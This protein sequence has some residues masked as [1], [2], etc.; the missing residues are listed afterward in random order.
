M[1]TLELCSRT[2][3]PLALARYLSTDELVFNPDTAHASQLRGSWFPVALE[4]PAAFH[5]T[6]A[7]SQNFVFKEMYGFFP[8]Q[9]DAQA[10][11]HHQKALRLT[12]DMMSDSSKHTSLDA[13]STIVSFTCHHVRI[14]LTLGDLY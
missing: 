2:V 11:M 13:L 3:R 10:L 7:N 6:L 12:R 4:T 8:S 9:D 14:R 5:N 1:I